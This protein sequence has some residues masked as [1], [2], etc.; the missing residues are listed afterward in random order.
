MS[1]YELLGVSKSASSTE[2]KK[3]YRKM[4]MKE[5]PDKGGDEEKFKEIATAYEVL[6]DPSKRQLYDQFGKEGVSQNSFTSPM[7][8]FSMFFG[9]KRNTKD[10][11]YPLNISLENLYVGKKLRIS[12]TRRRVKYPL[13]VTRKNALI[14]CK[15]CKGTGITTDTINIGLGFMQQMQNPCYK[16]RGKGKYM[17]KGIKIYEDK[18]QLT[19]NIPKGSK[20]GDKFTFSEEAD[21]QPGEKPRDV[22][23]IVKEKPHSTFQRKNSHLFVQHKISLWEALTQ[24]PI[25]I[26]H[27]DKSKFNVK[28]NHIINPKQLECVHGKGMTSQGNLYIQFTV[29][30]PTQLTQSERDILKLIYTPMEVD[31][32]LEF[33][34]L[35]PETPFF[36]ERSQSQQQPNMLQCAQQ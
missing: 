7:D 15:H 24:A 26:Q 5:H 35:V 34:N 9:E 29:D 2:I 21:E 23:F 4:A 36:N 12:I 8:I 27:L 17:Q 18:K 11:V 3:G 32:N 16:C 25:T 30:L 31:N 20:N 33:Y 6:S 1:Y 19:I 22:I 10:F 14:A 13:G 28:A